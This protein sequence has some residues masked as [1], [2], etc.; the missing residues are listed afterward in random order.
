MCKNFCLVVVMFFCAVRVNCSEKDTL[1]TNS[2]LQLDVLGK[3][4]VVGLT[5]ERIPNH[6]F[7]KL[8]EIPFWSLNV[9][10]GW[11]GYDYVLFGAGANRNWP[12]TKNTKLILSSGLSMAALI[13]LNPTPKALRDYWDSIHYTGGNYVNPVEPWLMWDIAVKHLFKRMFIRANFVT[14]LRYDR[15]SDSGFH[16]MPWG[17][18]SIGIY[19]NNKK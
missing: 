10:A 1:R 18:V 9:S 8:P 5:Y 19:L 11:P 4:Y 17:G 15:I 7:A 13:S 14:I 2:L 6:K 3:A 16:V 12:I